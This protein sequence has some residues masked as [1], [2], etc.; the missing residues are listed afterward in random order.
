MYTMHKITFTIFSID[1]SYIV[2]MNN[3]PLW[4]ATT[5]AISKPNNYTYV[6]HKL[7]LYMNYII[8]MEL[9]WHND[10]NM[11]TYNHNKIKLFGQKAKR[12]LNQ[13]NKTNILLFFFSFYIQIKKKPTTIEWLNLIWISNIVLVY[14]NDWGTVCGPNQTMRAMYKHERTG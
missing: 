10:K 13:N 2:Y 1:T 4:K 7:Y 5:V 14:S 3:M 12:Q 8:M 6:I 9:T 11:F